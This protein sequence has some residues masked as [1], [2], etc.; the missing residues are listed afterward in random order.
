[1]LV[2]ALSA[3]M[4]NTFH[5]SLDGYRSIANNIQYD[6]TLN[7]QDTLEIVSLFRD[8]KKEVF[9][10]N[11]ERWEIEEAS[12]LFS[13]VEYTLTENSKIILSLEEEMK[14][15]KKYDSITNTLNEIIKIQKEIDYF[16]KGYLQR[17]KEAD[18]ASRFMDTF[19]VKNKEV[20]EALA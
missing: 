12:D 11:F 17:A 8:Y 19:L 10:N 13:F 4:M 7:C 9:K 6:F 20:L 3:L 5:V 2:E 15:Y 18:E 1:M 16:T 14:Y